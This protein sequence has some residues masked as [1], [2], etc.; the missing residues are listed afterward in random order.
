MKQPNSPHVD[1]TKG[2]GQRKRNKERGQNQEEGE[3]EKYETT[4]GPYQR[5]ATANRWMELSG[6][7]RTRASCSKYIR[8]LGL[9][10]DTVTTLPKNSL[11]RMTTARFLL[12]SVS[13][14]HLHRFTRGLTSPPPCLRCPRLVALSFVLRCPAATDFRHPP[15]NGRPP[16]WTDVARGL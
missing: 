13:P 16:L 3:G 6:D 1:F 15:S 9:I 11:A 4:H 10:G 14:P 8:E 7:G 12:F 5:R 2:E